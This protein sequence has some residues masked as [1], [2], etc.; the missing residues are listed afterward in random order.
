M[1]YNQMWSHL[2]CS[3]Y[4]FALGIDLSLNRFS[5]TSPFADLLL[6]FCQVLPF[7]LLATGIVL[8]RQL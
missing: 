2:E 1:S 4:G 5:D 7:S 3:P 8:F 6:Y